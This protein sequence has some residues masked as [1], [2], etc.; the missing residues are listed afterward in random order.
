MKTAQNHA[1]G[2]P[3][4]ADKGFTQNPSKTCLLPTSTLLEAL[5]QAKAQRATTGKATAYAALLEHFHRAI[6]PA[7]FVECRGNLSEV[8]RLLGV[9]R[10]TVKLYAKLANIDT[11]G[12]TSQGG[13]L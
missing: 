1:I 10:E 3:A 2:A 11:T 8:S 13:V 5:T 9:H 4:P 6:L 12:A 7:F